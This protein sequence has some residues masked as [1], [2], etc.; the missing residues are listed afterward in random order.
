MG[1]SA[2]AQPSHASG[3]DVTE[4]QQ[5]S[6]VPQVGYPSSHFHNDCQ[7]LEGDAKDMLEDL[8]MCS[9]GARSNNRLQR[10]VRCAARR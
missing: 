3:D 2:R 9:N 4:L 5:A 10:T 6:A 7:Y 8:F 1:S